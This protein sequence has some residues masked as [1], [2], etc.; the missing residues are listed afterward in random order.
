MNLPR[1]YKFNVLQDGAKERKGI[2]NQNLA[3][4][5]PERRVFLHCY[6]DR[7]APHLV[8]KGYKPSSS[9]WKENNAREN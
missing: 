1:S 9:K 6:Y 8:L 2:S 3:L 4:L 5:Q 7:I